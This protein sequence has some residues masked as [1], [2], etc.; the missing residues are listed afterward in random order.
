M[1]S[2]RILVVGSG[3]REHA[4]AWRLAQDSEVSE[5]IVSPGNEGM[6]RSFRRLALR[7]T[8]GALLAK[9]AEA[10]KVGLAVIGPDAA[11]AAGVSDAFVA[12]R[13]PV[14]GPSRKRSSC[15]QLTRLLRK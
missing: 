13:I 7:E 12:A 14:Y 2:L 4:L 10:E 8:E 3:G 1:K 15:G 5:V 11:L 6:E 9:A